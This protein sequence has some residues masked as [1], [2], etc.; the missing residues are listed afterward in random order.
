MSDPSLSPRHASP[1]ALTAAQAAALI[2]QG[3]LTSVALTQACLDRIAAREDLNA[4]IAVDRDGAL[5]QAAASDVAR[6]QPGRTAGP[7]DGVPIAIKDNIHVAGLPNT[8]GTPAL[9]HFRPAEDAPIVRRLREAGA[10]PGPE[11]AHARTGS[12]CRATNNRVS[13]AR[14]AWARAM[15]TMPA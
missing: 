3:G 2:R 10:Y 1:A 5:A 14:T 13:P 8:A 15:P 12:A 9:R 4:F 6:G 7:L 11:P